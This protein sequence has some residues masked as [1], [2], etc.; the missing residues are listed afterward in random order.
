[1]FYSNSFRRVKFPVQQFYSSRYLQTPK[2]TQI[3][4]S[5]SFSVVTGSTEKIEKLNLTPEETLLKISA[6]GIKRGDR[7]TKS[8]ITSS[9]IGGSFLSVGGLLLLKVG[10]GSLSLLTSMPGLHSLLCGLVFPVGLVMIV[11]TGADLLTS[12]MIC[13]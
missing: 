12:N 13:M 8:I 7:S 9:L 11:M 4:F 2:Q 6:T 3:I 10:G 1:M 5:R